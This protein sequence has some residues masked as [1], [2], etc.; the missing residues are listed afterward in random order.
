MQISIK[1]PTA[2][3]LK[4]EKENKRKTDK[5]GKEHSTHSVLKFRQNLN[6]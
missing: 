1:E 6:C 2:V 5:I 4:K 3:I